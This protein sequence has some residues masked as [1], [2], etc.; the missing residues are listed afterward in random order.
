MHGEE[1]ADQA[2]EQYS[3]L[4]LEHG[5]H[6]IATK[7]I[8]VGNHQQYAVEAEFAEDL[9]ELP[10]TLKIKKDGTEVEVPLRLRKGPMPKLD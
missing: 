3:D 2:R 1:E 8:R 6:A 7:L 5:A 10:S 9:P 4:L